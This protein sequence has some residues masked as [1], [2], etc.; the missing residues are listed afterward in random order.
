MIESEEAMADP[1][2]WNLGVILPVRVC[3]R[4]KRDG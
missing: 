2:P 3:G 1:N 4:V